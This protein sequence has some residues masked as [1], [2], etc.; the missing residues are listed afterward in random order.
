[1]VVPVAGRELRAGIGGGTGEMRGTETLAPCINGR[2]PRPAIARYAS[3]TRS[4]R[5][6]VGTTGLR[7]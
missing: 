6:Q 1:M 4:A 2:A 3:W 7:G 5:K